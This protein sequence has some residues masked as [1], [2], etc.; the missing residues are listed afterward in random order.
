MADEQPQYPDPRASADN[1]DSSSSK[2]GPKR[3]ASRAGT[4]S[5]ASLTPEQLARKRAN[6]REAQ[7]SIR[8]RTKT[9][10]EELEQRIRYLSDGKDARDLEQIKR[11]N[12]ELEE[13]LRRLREILG[14][15][16]GSVASSP[17]LTPMSNQARYGMDGLEDRYPMEYSPAW[18]SPTN[19]VSGPDGSFQACPT[20]SAG[21]LLSSFAPDHSGLPSEFSGPGSTRNDGFSADS[22]VSNVTSAPFIPV[23]VRSGGSASRPE[24]V[25]SRSYPHGRFGVPAS[26]GSARMTGGASG[27]GSS[28]FTGQSLSP[29]GDSSMVNK[30]AKGVVMS[31]STCHPMT[32]DVKNA[33]ME[34]HIQQNRP[35]YTVPQGVFANQP[36]L[37]A[38]EIPI[39]FAP[40]AGPVESI[41]IGLLQ[42]QKSLANES[43]L[44][45]LLVGPYHPD[46]RALVNP[47][48]SNK[49]HPVS[50]VISNVFQRLQYPSLAAKVA[51]VYLV[52]RFF[53]WQIWPTMETW[54]N[55]PEWFYPVASQ[56]VTAHPIWMSLLTWGKLRDTVINNQDK[57][58]TEQFS[59][60][61]RTAINLNWPYG[62]E[63]ILVFIGEEVR[64]T[65][66]FMRHLEQEANWSLD[67]PF[68]H[69]Y[70]EL[71]EACR[72]TSSQSE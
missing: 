61:W 38:W 9:H 20:S 50:S 5:V 3:R 36:S 66:A 2:A 11:R 35:N 30:D 56:Q 53:Q 64:I 47:E 19:S 46:L 10:I 55:M 49:V 26:H 45:S 24:F 68:Q 41:L 57:Y 70:P 7:R 40:P 22:G 51:S 6:D 27:I 15:S 39:H 13:E 62:E 34:L 18:S 21:D 71:R 65:D 67:E 44:G 72:F 60:L 63:D 59:D 37:A 33:R 69:R 14:R 48:M 31:P 23:P 54:R 1:G 8:Q 16:E 12:A 43:T 29:V 28:P 25:R 42:R 58:A 4:R 52:Y 32:V 17:E